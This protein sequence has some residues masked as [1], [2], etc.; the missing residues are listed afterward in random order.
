MEDEPPKPY[1][2][3]FPEVSVWPDPE[4]PYYTEFKEKIRELFAHRLEGKMTEKRLRKIALRVLNTS[5]AYFNYL[6]GIYGDMSKEDFN[7]AVE[8]LKK[9]NNK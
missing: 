1:P 2:M 5:N 8:E 6:L 3:R 9:E 4:P 7:K